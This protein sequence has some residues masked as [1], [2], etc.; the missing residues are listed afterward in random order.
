MNTGIAPKPVLLILPMLLIGCVEQELDVSQE[1]GERLFKKEIARA[2]MEP[3]DAM[4]VILVVS[5]LQ[6]H[7]I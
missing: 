5:F 1:A 3:M 2:A 6:F 7:L 4:M